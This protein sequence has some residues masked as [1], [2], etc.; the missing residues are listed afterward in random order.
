MTIFYSIGFLITLSVDKIGIYRTFKRTIRG[1][2][3]KKKMLLLPG[4][5]FGYLILVRISTNKELD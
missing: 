1:T 4:L 2:G 3:K 5:Y